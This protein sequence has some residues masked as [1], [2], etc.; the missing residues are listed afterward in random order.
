MNAPFILQ[1]QAGLLYRQ[2]NSK[3]SY[4]SL[5]GQKDSF[6]I[7]NL[8]PATEY[9]IK[10]ATM[11]RDGLPGIFRTIISRTFGTLKEKCRFAGGLSRGNVVAWLH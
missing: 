7:Q 2:N 4:I 10:V 6:N 5:G 1:R 11:D 8:S 3:T 9:E